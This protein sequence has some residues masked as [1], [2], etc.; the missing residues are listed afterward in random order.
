MRRRSDGVG[1]VGQ[2][3]VCRLVEGKGE[4][5]LGCCCGRDDAC[6]KEE[7]VGLMAGCVT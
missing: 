2:M 3:V 4:I 1:D 5:Y 7:G 6:V